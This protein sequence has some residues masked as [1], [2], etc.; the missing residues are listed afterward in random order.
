M[1]KQLWHSQTMGY[2]SEVEYA[3]ACMDPQGIELSEKS[4][5]QDVA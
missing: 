4:Q 1:G 2:Y 3:A 5:F